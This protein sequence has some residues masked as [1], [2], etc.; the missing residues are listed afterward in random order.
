MP[1]S[2]QSLLQ[3]QRCSA[4]PG[5]HHLGASGEDGIGRQMWS[6][7]HQS[8]RVNVHYVAHALPQIDYLLDLSEQGIPRTVPY[9]PG[10]LAEG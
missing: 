10:W 3:D 7:H 5:D 4:W 2:F 6:P 8:Q 1:M 9:L